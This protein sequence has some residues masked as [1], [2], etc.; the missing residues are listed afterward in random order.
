[1]KITDIKFESYMWPRHTPI[2]N[3]LYT[4]THS[5]VNIV[6]VETDTGVSGLG[7]CSGTCTS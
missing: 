6:T 2:T 4:N 7:L 1:M 3:G 5:G